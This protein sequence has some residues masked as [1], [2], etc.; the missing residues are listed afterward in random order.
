ME[1]PHSSVPL[2]NAPIAPKYPSCLKNKLCTVPLD[3]NL[4]EKDIVCMLSE[5]FLKK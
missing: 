1:L 2:R 5:R 4:I 3:Q